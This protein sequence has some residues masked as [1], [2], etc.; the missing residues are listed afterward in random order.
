[1]IFYSV[2]WRGNLESVRPHP[3]VYAGK[4]EEGKWWSWS[5]YGIG[6]D[7]PGGEKELEGRR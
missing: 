7:F 2:G 4:G 5:N 1:M 6:I 3:A